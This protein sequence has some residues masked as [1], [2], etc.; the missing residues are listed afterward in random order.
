MSRARHAL[1]AGEIARAAFIPGRLEVLGKHTDYAGGRSVLAALERGIGV[2]FAPREDAVV[3]VRDATGGASP[4]KIA[5]AISPD[6]A[7][8]VGEWPNYP[9]TVARRLARN[10]PGK[11]RGADIALASDLPRAAGLSSSSAL[12]VA[13]YHAL[14]TVNDLSHRAEYTT[15]IE[16][17]EDVAA[18]LGAIENGSAF[19][20]LAG[21]LGVGTTGGSEDHTAML[22]AREDELVA[23]SF[24]PIRFERTAPL[25]EGYTFVIAVSGVVAEKTGAAR[26]MYNRSAMLAAALLQIWRVHTRRE[27]ASL[28]AALASSPGAL[29]ELREV[30]AATEPPDGVS[31]EDLR[32]RLDHF[33]LESMELIPAALDAL[34]AGDVKA[35]GELADRSQRGA[36]GLLGNQVAETIALQRRARALGAAAAS[37]FGAGFGGSV[38]AMV[39]RE[40]AERFADEWVREVEGADA[41]TS[42]A[43]AAMR[44][45]E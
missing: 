20:T 42:A 25:P 36:E 43:G 13:V 40:R 7:P 38:W 14:S 44:E 32:R 11:L 2:A 28:G 27:D 26:E 31:R 8:T 4:S 34:A 18:Y 35:F 3:R 17:R 19:K 41:F 24:C 37:A 23:Y 10:F 21:D 16:T 22:C 29:N 33:A 6:L 39:E 1:G 15:A 12:T 45:G 5:F 9:M 30:V